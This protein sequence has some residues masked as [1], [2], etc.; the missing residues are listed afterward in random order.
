MSRIS[1]DTVKSL[2]PLPFLASQYRE[3]PAFPTPPITDPLPSTP[4]T[5]NP[6]SPS[7]P[8]THLPLHPTP[9]SSPPLRRLLRRLCPPQPPNQPT[10]PT[11]NPSTQTKLYPH[12]TD[13][14]THT[15]PRRILQQRRIHRRR[16]QMHV[17]N[18]TPPD[19]DVLDR[20]LERVSRLS[21]QLVPSKP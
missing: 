19:K 6:L 1:F 20:R 12:P 17:A 9:P 2:L 8:T 5:R 4:T 3:H 15:S 7:G 10:K 21:D 13:G 11:A 18:H 16:R 14:A